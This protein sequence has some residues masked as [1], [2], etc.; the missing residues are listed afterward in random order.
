MREH[1]YWKNDKLGADSEFYNGKAYIYEIF[2][3]AEDKPKKITHYFE[4]IVKNKVVLDLGCGTGKFIPDFA[5]LAK[6][7]IAIDISKNQL[8][9]AR[10]KSENF[11]N[12]ELIKSSA[13][14]IPVESNSIDIVIANWFIGSIHNIP[15]RDKIIKEIKR[16]IRISGS[17]Y[18]TEND[19]GGKYKDIIENS[20]GKEKTKIKLKWLEDVGF[21]K[22]ASIKTYFEF[23]SL[24]SARE[25]LRNIWVDKIASNVNRRKISHNIVIYKYGK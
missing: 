8:E 17:I 21:K 3:Q 16:I 19:V 13:H 2:S 14:K 7:Y 12:V 1:P 23:E 22:V 20:Y 25:T 6:K 4:Q 24:Q 11:T 10:K 9:I 18:F 5:P 15:L